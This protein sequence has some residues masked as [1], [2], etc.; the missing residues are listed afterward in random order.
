METR[1]A[2]KTMTTTDIQTEG[3]VPGGAK[4]SRAKLDDP[5]I[6]KAIGE[7]LLTRD[8]STLKDTLRDTLKPEAGTAEERKKN[9]KTNSMRRRRSRSGRLSKISSPAKSGRN[10]GQRPRDDSDPEAQFDSS[11]EAAKD[12]VAGE[13]SEA[14]GLATEPRK[15]DKLAALTEEV[16]GKVAALVEAAQNDTA[17]NHAA[18]VAATALLESEAETNLYKLVQGASK[19]PEQIS[20]LATY[21]YARYLNLFGRH[22]GRRASASSSGD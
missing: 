18:Y 15:G 7:E 3:Q 20:F 12:Q 11:V 13:V 2:S 19:S 8:S 4:P 10:A 9:A 17:E 5:A 22:V 14:S 6:W 1:G 16:R 21:L